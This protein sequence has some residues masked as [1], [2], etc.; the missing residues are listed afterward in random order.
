M[1]GKT[2]FILQEGKDSV[3]S[4]AG[5]EQRFSPLS[6]LEVLKWTLERI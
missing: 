3:Q 6:I 4:R 2:I 1:E 5:I